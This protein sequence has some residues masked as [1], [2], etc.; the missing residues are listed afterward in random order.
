MTSRIAWLYTALV[1]SAAAALL[2]LAVPQRLPAAVL[3]LT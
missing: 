1:V 2:T 3:D